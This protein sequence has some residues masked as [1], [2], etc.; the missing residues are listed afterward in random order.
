MFRIRLLAIFTMICC[1]SSPHVQ[2]RLAILYRIGE[3]LTPVLVL[4]VLCERLKTIVFLNGVRVKR[5]WA[6]FAPSRSLVLGKQ[7][8]PNT[9]TVSFFSLALFL[10]QK[11]QNSASPRTSPRMRRHIRDFCDGFAQ[12]PITWLA[13]KLKP[14]VS[15][16]S[17]SKEKVA[18]ERLPALTL[19]EFRR[20]SHGNCK[21]VTEQP[22]AWGS[23]GK[24]QSWLFQPLWIIFFI[25]KFARS[26]LKSKCPEKS[27]KIKF[28]RQGLK[29]SLRS[30]FAYC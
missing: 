14:L 25:W 10:W 16:D 17:L 28:L 6:R 27:N 5:V 19:C 18:Q 12:E 23:L 30:P 20:Y 9:L 26:F 3:L 13:Q 1:C 7:F 4:R 21:A 29:T 15:L 8:V 24:F 22:E 2:L 11:G